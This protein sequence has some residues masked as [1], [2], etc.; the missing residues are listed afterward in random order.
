VKVLPTPAA[1]ITPLGDLDICATGSVVLHANS[2][3]GFSYQW[4][5]GN[6]LLAGQT[7]QNYTAVSKGT[8][9]LTVTGSN[10]CSKTSAAVK[11]TSSCKENFSEK[12]EILFS[13]YPNPVHDQLTINVG[14]NISGNVIIKIRSITG[15]EVIAIP[16]TKSQQEIDVQHLPAGVYFVTITQNGKLVCRE[17]V[18]KS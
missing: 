13:V 9:R 6:N 17:K 15:V 14:E 12:N 4:K 7:N 5:K 3:S 10:G 18:V 8:Y 2:G 16:L 1:I 11:V